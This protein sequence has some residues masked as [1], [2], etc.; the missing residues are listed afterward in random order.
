MILCTSTPYYRTI[1]RVSCNRW[2]YSQ[3][4]VGKVVLV[5][6]VYILSKK[7]IGSFQIVSSGISI[8]DINVRA[9]CQLCLSCCTFLAG[10]ERPRLTWPFHH[11][12]GYHQVRSGCPCTFGDY[13][14]R[15]R[16]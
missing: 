4:T 14:A 13:Q 2:S 10:R 5:N 16:P 1:E 15:L 7:Y 11:K 12:E 9:L 6:V 3:C 8:K